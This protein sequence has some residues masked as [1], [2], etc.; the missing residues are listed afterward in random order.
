MNEPILEPHL[1]IVDAH[2]HLWDRRA[3]LLRNQPPRRPHGFNNVNQ[4]APR[5]LLDELLT[6]LGRGH[7]I[8]ATVYVECGA[9]FRAEGPPEL[10]PVGETE[11]VNGVAAMSASGLYGVPRACAAIVGRADLSLG[12]RVRDVLESHIRAGGDR[13]RGIRQIGAWDADATVLG[14]LAGLPPGFYRDTRFRTG[15]AELE[16]L[17]LSFDA[18]LLEPQLSDLVDLAQAFPGTQIILDHLGTPLGIASYE[19]QRERRFS[20]W[21]ASI[22]ALAKL[23]NVAVKLG[24]LGMVFPGF[25]AFMA[26]TPSPSAQLANEWRPY[27]ESC[28]EAFGVHRAMFESNFPVD[29][30]TCSYDV[31]W[32]TFKRLTA[33]CSPEEKAAL[34]GGTATRIYKLSL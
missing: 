9:F 2:H 18:W 24:G 27:V 6:D 3:H 33:G 5:Y 12:P 25:P 11:F 20:E 19:G 30:C 26:A 23:P 10:R 32:N 15:F 14:H 34:F 31:L 13:F 21:Q 8:L 16:P 28:I 29:F 7:N 1:P 17:G 4:Q 22:R